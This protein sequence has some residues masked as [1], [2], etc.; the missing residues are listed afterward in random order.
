MV[1][2]IKE[3][4]YAG[5]RFRTMQVLSSKKVVE[6]TFAVPCEIEN[7]VNCAGLAEV[8]SGSGKERTLRFVDSGTNYQWLLVDGQ[9]FHG[10][11]KSA[12]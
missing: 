2:Q 1:D 11:S 5:L 3:K 8:M 9:V 4:S 7:D 12:L 10:F 6:E